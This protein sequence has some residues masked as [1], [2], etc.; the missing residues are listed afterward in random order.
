MILLFKSI[1]IPFHLLNSEWLMLCLSERLIR[2][3][4]HLLNVGLACDKQ[5]TCAGTQLILLNFPMEPV[6]PAASG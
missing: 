1:P 2:L 4:I 6:L 5:F 3:R